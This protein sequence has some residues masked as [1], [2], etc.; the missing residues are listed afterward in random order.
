MQ[1]T[2]LGRTGLAVSRTA[3]GCLPL[4][5]LSMDEAALLLQKAYEGGINFFDTARAYTDSE[6][7]I[8]FALS[9]V[10]KEIV[11]ATKTMADNVQ[12]FWKQ[13]E[14][15][16][17]KLKTDYIDIYQF[18]NPRA[19]PL[20]GIENGIYE[21]ALEAKTKGLIRHIGISQHSLAL[22]VEAVCSGLYETIQY[23]FNH[24]ATDAELSLAPLCGQ[25]NIGFICMKALSGGLIT[26]ASVSFVFIRRFQNAVPIWGFQ[27]TAELQ[28]LLS[29]EEKEP[30]YDSEMEARILTDRKSLAGSFCR[31]CGYC[32]PCPAGIPIHQAN[33]MKQLLTRMPPKNWITP[34]WREEMLKIENCTKCGQCEK[35]CPYGLKPHETLPGHLRFY[36]DFIQKTR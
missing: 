34:Q 31:S 20:P 29:F 33:R 25:R 14:T 15:S 17:E 5:R 22:A 28:L 16:L 8:G 4:Q 36:L 30:A 11:I 35:R 2:I 23:P 7:K 26:D 18:H 21:A 12:D 24:L 13:L 1:K 10:R 27:R 9:D 32:L 3:F 19:V 6:Q